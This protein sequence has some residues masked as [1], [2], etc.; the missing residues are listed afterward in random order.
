MQTAAGLE[1]FRVKHPFTLFGIS[2]GNTVPC[3]TT[4][5]PIPLLLRVPRTHQAHPRQN[6]AM[7]PPSSFL[8]RAAHSFLCWLQSQGIT[9]SPKPLCAQRDPRDHAHTAPDTS[10]EEG[11]GQRGALL[12]PEPISRASWEAWRFPEVLHNQRAEMS[13]PRGP[14]RTE[15]PAL[16]SSISSIKLK[17]CW[18]GSLAHDSPGCAA[19]SQRDSCFTAPR[20]PPAAQQ[21]P[22]CHRGAGMSR[23][24]HPEELLLPRKEPLARK[25]GFG[26][27]PLRPRI[28]SQ[29][30]PGW[31]N[32]GRVPDATYTAQ[33]NGVKGFPSR[34]ANGLCSSNNSRQSSCPV[35]REGQKYIST[36]PPVPHLQQ[37]EGTEGPSV[38]PHIQR[39][40]GP[41]GCTGPAAP[42]C[43]NKPIPQHRGSG[44]VSSLAA[45]LLHFR[46]F[47]TPHCLLKDFTA[48]LLVSL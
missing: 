35:R 17:A 4:A 8:H 38:S 28:L 47:I 13:H 9:V 11:L 45:K 5:L 16:G 36:Q 46:R 7:S 2:Q 1:L 34:Y 15:P 30:S 37:Q 42:K 24:Y 44:F 22:P 41:R 26:A 3:Q 32:P 19:R 31:K 48:T 18:H 29:T 33:C 25:A 40:R 14:A 27:P 21:L 12:P 43:P 39:A 10:E 20:G 6:V 23:W